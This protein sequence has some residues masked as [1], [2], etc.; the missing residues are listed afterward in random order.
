MNTPQN[1]NDARPSGQSAAGSA[2]S[3]TERFARALGANRV[4]EIGKVANPWL[5]LPGKVVAV[6][7]SAGIELTGTIVNVNDQLG[8]VLVSLFNGCSLIAKVEEPFEISIP[9]EGETDEK[10]RA[11]E[12]EWWSDFYPT[13]PDKSWY[14]LTLLK[15]DVVNV[16]MSDGEWRVCFLH[17]DKEGK[18]P[19]HKFEG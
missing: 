13:A 6:A 8:E 11:A 18:D 2:Q 14:G 15:G 19:R 5:E 12:M 9:E 16:R 7:N 10:H 4:V 3:E 1:S 17:L